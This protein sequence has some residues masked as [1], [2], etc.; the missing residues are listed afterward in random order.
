MSDAHGAGQPV[1]IKKVKKGGHSG[2]HG[3]AW[4]I[5]YADFVTAMMAFFLLM[6]LVAATSEEQ[7]RGVAEYFTPASF[8]VSS[9]GTGGIMGDTG[10]LIQGPNQ[11]DSRAP[12]VVMRIAPSPS[13]GAGEA[14]AED[15]EGLQRRLEEEAFEEAQAAIRQAIDA[16]PA[17]DELSDR[18]IIDMTPEG[19]R[20]QVVDREGGAMFP[21]G[22]SEI[23][24]RTTILLSQI[25]KVVNS[26][27]NRILITDHTDATSFGTG[28]GYTNWELSADRAN[29]AR[30]ALVVA[31]V[32]PERVGEVAGRADQEPLIAENPFLPED[33][34]ISIVLQRQAP[35]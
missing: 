28:D 5:A 26:M 6:W 18:L 8:S 16:D 14:D 22:S 35:V 13:S 1:I 31:G 27:P 11:S 10:L 24:E 21:S 30:R 33:R 25:A 15:V 9:S 12:T 2:H 20:I 3:G 32:D 17:L 34:R 23:P 7:K 19:L 4:K 29:A